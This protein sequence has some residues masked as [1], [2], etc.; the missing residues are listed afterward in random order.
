MRLEVRF[1]A[2]PVEAMR[3][4][5]EPLGFELDWDPEADGV[6]F[7]WRKP[8]LSGSGVRALHHPEGEQGLLVIETDEEASAADAA[9]QDVAARLLAERFEDVAVWCRTTERA[10]YAGGESADP[11]APGHD[12]PRWYS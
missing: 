10:E 7:L 3:A 4:F 6:G 11:P 5:L 2:V 1:A 12:L 8:P 9:M